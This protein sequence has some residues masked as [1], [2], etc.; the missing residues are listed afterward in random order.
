MLLPSYICSFYPNAALQLSGCP[1][2]QRAGCLLLSN[3]SSRTE[4][5]QPAISPFVG[6]APR[7]ERAACVHTRVRTRP[8]LICCH[9]W[10][11]TPSPSPA[12]AA[13]S[14]PPRRVFWLRVSLLTKPI[15]CSGH[16][17]SSCL[18]SFCISSKI[19]VSHSHVIAL[20]SERRGRSS[21][22]I[23]IVNKPPSLTPASG[24]TWFKP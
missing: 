18:V 14:L 8:A 20:L 23:S 3:C 9:G 10:S 13:R 2:P 6:L 24:H 15:K 21:S 11:A 1:S 12:V 22:A 16:C 7:A 17:R 19:S 5:D 4:F